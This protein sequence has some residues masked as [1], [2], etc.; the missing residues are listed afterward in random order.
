MNPVAEEIL[1]HIGMPRRSGRYPWGSGED[2]YQHAQDFLGRIEQLK[3]QGWTETPENIMEEFGLTTTQYRTEKAVC[4]D[5]RG[6][7]QRARA[8]SLAEDGKGPTEIGREMG[9]SESTVRGWL[10][11]KQTESNMQQARNTADILKTRMKEIE[12]DG[13]MLDVGTGVEREL[14]ISKEK[15][16]QALYLLEREGYVTYNGRFE[17]PTNKG[18]WTTQR[19]LCQPDMI[20]KGDAKAPADIYDLDRIHTVEKY[21]SRDGGETFSKFVYPASLDSKRLMIRYNEE[22]GLERDGTIELRRGVADISLGNDRYSQ[23]RILVDGSHYLKGMALYSDNMPDGVDV[24]FNTNKTKGTP[25]SKVLKEIKRDPDGNPMENPFGSLIKPQGQSEYTDANG[26][27]HLS[28]INKTRGE[29]EWSEWKDSLPSQF[30][31]KQSLA[32]A[33]KQLNLAKADKLDEFETLCSLNQPTVKKHLLKKFAD[34]C[35]AAAADL[36]AAALPGQKYHVIIPVNSLKDHEVYAPNYE[37]GTKLALIRYPHGGKFE[38]PIL[39]VNNKHAAARKLLGTDIVDAIG[40]NSKNAERLSGADFDGDTVMCIPTHDPQGKVKIKNQDPLKGLEGFDPKTAYAERPGMKYMK[41]P[42]TGKDS[43]Q[44]EMGKISNLITDMTLAGASDSELARAV[45][46][47]MVV[48]DAGKHKLDYKKSEIDNGIDSL[49]KKYQPKYDEN[50]NL[51]GRG[52]GASTILSKAK[53]DYTADRRQGTAKVN[54]KGSKDYDPSRPEG[55]LLYKT[56]DDL[57]YPDRKYDKKTKTVTLRTTEGKKITYQI[58]DADAHS[59]Y[60]PVKRVDEKTGVV[61]YTDKSGKITYHLNKRTQGS[62]QMAETDDAYTLVSK[63]RHPMEIVYADYA[64]SMKALAN[65][66]RLE[67]VAT[68][69]AKYSSS[70][71]KTYQRE[72]DELMAA[73]NTAEI[74][75]PRE[76]AAQRKAAADIAAKKKVDD[77]LSKGDLKK[78]ATQAV[79]KYRDEVGS[80]SRNDRSIKINDRTW[81][82]IMAG[83]VTDNTLQRILKN[84]DVD[85]LRE[86][87]TPR[88]NTN[89]LNSAKINRIKQLSA[90]NYTLQQIAEKM[91][92]SPSTVSKYLKGEN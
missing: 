3:K 2:P 76:R 92:L 72:V 23:V 56:A 43:T 44:M 83:A 78:L 46:H 88:N 66:A 90:S 71:K 84:T 45:R 79:T 5:T 50:G 17:Q 24:V 74:N 47:S 64:N 35:D 12:K 20:P 39:I 22:G 85:S 60:D 30:L 26:K 53:G 32:M 67:M 11:N 58:D 86:R 63:A 54:V 31:G 36:K 80:V 37:N 33:K 19:I 62:T 68:P 38:I 21:F 29:G 40:I 91:N 18:R 70:A 6:L 10:Q 82:A 55:A 75:T 42:K 27:K 8:K 49:K 59:K 51:T 81:E 4:K 73:L 7:L 61:T 14:G 15:M 13:G 65:Q 34:E 69:T 48:I 16:E 41:D 1:M 25:M 52:G 89:R 28:L 57:Y 77:T 9:V 87:A